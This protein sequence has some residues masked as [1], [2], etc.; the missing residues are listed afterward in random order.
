MNEAFISCPVFVENEL[1]EESVADALRHS[2]LYL[3]VENQR[4]DDPTAVVHDDVTIYAHLQRLAVDFDD[5]R[6][7]TACGGPSLRP[8]VVGGFQPGLGPRLDGAAHRIGR[9][10]SSPRGI[11]LCGRP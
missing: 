11:A 2:T 9:T 3:A 4:V 1:L 5:H 7:D 6:V 10:A 8:E